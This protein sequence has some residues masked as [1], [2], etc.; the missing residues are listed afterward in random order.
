MNNWLN[1]FNL[2]FR[3]EHPGSLDFN[4]RLVDLTLR[5]TYRRAR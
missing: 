4:N 1:D 3:T 5:D 2:Y